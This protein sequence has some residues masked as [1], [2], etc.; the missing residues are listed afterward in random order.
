MYTNNKNN[1]NNKKKNEYFSWKNEY[2]L[3]KIYLYH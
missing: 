3:N 2:D 1:N